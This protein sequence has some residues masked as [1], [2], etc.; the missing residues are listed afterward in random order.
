M[1]YVC[2]VLKNPEKKIFFHNDKTFE[3]NSK[4][5]INN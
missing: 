4:D 3:Y 5:Y 2:C 1:I